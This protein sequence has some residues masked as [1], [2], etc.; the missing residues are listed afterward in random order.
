MYRDQIIGRQWQ[1]SV[2]VHPN[3]AMQQYDRQSLEFYSNGKGHMHARTLFGRNREF[4]WEFDG[5]GFVIY[6]LG[7]PGSVAFAVI[8]GGK[9]SVLENGL[10]MIYT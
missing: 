2:C 7:G 3:G 8:E 5:E 10:L 9:L 6:N 1:S 4:S